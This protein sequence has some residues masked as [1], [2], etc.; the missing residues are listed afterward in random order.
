[1]GNSG[2]QVIMGTREVCKRRAKGKRNIRESKL[3]GLLTRYLAAASP[4]G[5]SKHVAP[6]SLHCARSSLIA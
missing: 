3:G 2:D 5:G 6:A 1:M 4:N